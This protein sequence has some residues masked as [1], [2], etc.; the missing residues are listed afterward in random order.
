MSDRKI[1]S[2]KLNFKEGLMTKEEKKAIKSENKERI[3][4]IKEFL[5]KPENKEVR[6]YVRSGGLWIA[7]AALTT[8]ITGGALSGIIYDTMGPKEENIIKLYNEAI[9]F[10]KER[11]AKGDI[12][13]EEFNENVEE[14][15]KECQKK[16][17]KN[18]IFTRVKSLSASA[19]IGMTGAVI[20][21]SV[22]DATDIV[23][24]RAMEEAKLSSK[25]K[26]KAQ[27]DEIIKKFIKGKK[28]E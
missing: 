10:E 25:T 8:L 15:E 21:D 28:S 17:K 16:L 18:H 12:T 26:T 1:Y 20:I 2:V 24:N 19:F 7:G 3:R 9:N 22:M 13:Q 4:E 27:Q 11:L 23:V 6:K 5:K 14:L